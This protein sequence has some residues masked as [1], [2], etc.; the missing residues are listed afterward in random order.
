MGPLGTVFRFGTEE[1]EKKT[2]QVREI[3]GQKMESHG[4]IIYVFW[5]LRGGAL[6]LF[7]RLFFLP[8]LE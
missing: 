1:K 4:R 7:I 5:F 6:F 8:Y 3:W 2:E